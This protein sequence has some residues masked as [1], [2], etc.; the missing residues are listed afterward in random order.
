[1]CLDK[2]YLKIV[3][4][5]EN[6]VKIN[7]VKI[8][9]LSYYSSVEVESV[10]VRSGVSSQPVD[11]METKLGAH[12]RALNA[13]LSMPDADFWVGIE[14]GIQH[15]EKHTTA[16]AW[17]IILSKNKSGE[18]RTTTFLLPSKVS[19]FVKKGSELGTA[20]DI[21]FGQEN[22]KQKSGAVGSLTKNNVS[23][24]QLYVQAV[25]LALIPFINPELF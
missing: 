7:A 14:G 20:I 13:K 3:V 10:K 6:P 8:G 4:A 21:V 23:R 22:S 25:Q 1:M 17:I 18:A 9:F 2:N 12:N 5:S 19:E 15:S 11:D 24:T 16:F